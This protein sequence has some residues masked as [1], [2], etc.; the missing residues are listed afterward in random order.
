M[1]AVLTALDCRL[2]HIRCKRKLPP[3]PSAW[4]K[5]GGK[6]VLARSPAV[7][8]EPRPDVLQMAAYQFFGCVR[9]GGLD[10]VENAGVFVFRTC[11]ACG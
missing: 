11:G 9:I 5:N 6:V 8:V 1:V 3:P 2:I 7:Q 10:G 4:R